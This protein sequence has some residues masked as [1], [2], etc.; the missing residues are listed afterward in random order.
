M[1][2]CQGEGD[3]LSDL[4]S[5][6]NN[7]K[8][9]SGNCTKSEQPSPSALS[10]SLPQKPKAKASVEPLYKNCKTARATPIP[11][12][13]TP[14]DECI[15][16]ARQRGLD[17]GTVLAKF[18]AHAK[19]RGWKRADWQAAFMKWI[20]DEK[21]SNK[22]ESV[23]KPAE[24]RSTVPDFVEPEPVQKASRAVVD[25]HMDK[26]RQMLGRKIVSHAIA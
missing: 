10:E 20:L 24:V 21:V 23:G 11:P 15:G 5:K 16:I 13:F 22:S 17:L 6:E 14:N 1:T 2:D 19:A 3:R 12:D 9:K 8:N 7:K 4:N 18:V 25:S 26:I